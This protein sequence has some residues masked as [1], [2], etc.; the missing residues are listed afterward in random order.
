MDFSIP[1]LCVQNRYSRTAELQALGVMNH[2]LP[3]IKTTLKEAKICNKVHR[4]EEKQTT[5]QRMV[6]S[7]FLIF[8]GTRNRRLFSLAVGS[9]PTAAGKQ[10]D[11]KMRRGHFG[12]E[13]L[14]RLIR[15]S[16]GKHEKDRKTG[17]EKVCVECRVLQNCMHFNGGALCVSSE[18]CTCMGR[19]FKYEK[20]CVSNLRVYRWVPGGSGWNT[21][22]TC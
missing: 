4:K 17:R 20:G 21:K 2:S 18:V 16:R 3:L 10:R 8:G 22:Q 7:P 14:K 6:Q 15:T 19:Y 5:Q 11:E 12:I 13:R 1:L 9:H